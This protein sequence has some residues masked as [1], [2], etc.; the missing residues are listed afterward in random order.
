MPSHNAIVKV[1]QKEKE[2]NNMGLSLTI[3]LI[4]VLCYQVV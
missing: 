1:L 4:V 3:K 2:K